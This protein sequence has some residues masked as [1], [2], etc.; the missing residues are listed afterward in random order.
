M[1]K[2]K[3]N[4]DED[5][6]VLQMY[7]C[8]VVIFNNVN[9][10]FSCISTIVVIDAFLRLLFDCRFL[11]FFLYMHVCVCYVKKFFFHDL[12]F[13][14]FIA[15]NLLLLNGNYNLT[16]VNW[17]V[18][19]LASL[20]ISR[21]EKSAQF[22]WSLFVATINLVY[23]SQNLKKCLIT[24]NWRVAVKWILSNWLIYFEVNLDIDLRSRHLYISDKQNEFRIRQE[25]KGYLV[26]LMRTK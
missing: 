15:Y 16:T 24:I 10:C 14:F 5:D 3:S 17:Q 18:E 20:L 25:G 23:V 13:I 2:P 19:N 6:I 1:A 11:L 26:Q 21:G 7:H 22:L 4:D 8:W 9:R 12:T